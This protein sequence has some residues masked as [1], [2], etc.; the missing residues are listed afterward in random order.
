MNKMIKRRST[1]KNLI[2]SNYFI[3]VFSRTQDRPLLNERDLMREIEETFGLPVRLIQLEHLKINE[4]IEIMSKI[5]VSIGLYGSALVYAMFMP[6][7]SILVESVFR[8]KIILPTE[9]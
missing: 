1:D 9:D 6:A 5:V 7:K 3:S 2:S 4:I 8:V